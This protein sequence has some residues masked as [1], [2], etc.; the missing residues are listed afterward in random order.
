[1]IDNTTAVA[2]INNMGG[3][4]SLPCNSIAKEI[5]NWCIKQNI[6]LSAAHLPGIKNVA[7]DKASRIFYDNT[8]WMLNRVI[9]DKLTL[10]LFKP[11]LDLF[12]SRINNQLNKYVSWKPGPGAYAID[13]FT[14]DWSTD[15]FFAF[16]PF[17]LLGRVV[18]KIEQ[19]QAEGIVIVPN[20]PSQPW[21]PQVMRLAVTAPLI[22]PKGK[23]I[24]KLPYDPMKIHPLYP[25]L[26]LLAC[27]LS[28]NHCK[29]RASQRKH[30]KLSCHHGENQ[31]RD[32]MQDICR[33]GKGFVVEDKLICFH[34]L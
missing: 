26:V 30:S 13:A 32:S 34:Q 33:S 27:H 21:Y 5:W 2:Y 6:W 1:M 15:T 28:G 24:L 11:K 20:W 22:L 8:E 19:D 23:N 12:A 10:K 29:V 4:H 9:F 17:S 18:Q 3:S 31:H 25:K 16:P 7:A 14:L